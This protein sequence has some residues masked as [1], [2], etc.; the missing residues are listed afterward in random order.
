MF[1]QQLLQWKSNKYYIFWVCV[2]SFRYPACNAHVPCCLLR[3]VRLHYV[4]P[5]C[6]I[7]GMIFGK[8][9]FEHKMCV[10]ILCPK[11]VFNISHSQKNWARYDQK[12]KLVFM[13][14]TCH[15]H[16]ILIEIEFSWHIFWK[17]TEISNFIQICQYKL[18]CSMRSGR[19]S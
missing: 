6:L 8:N 9:V 19:Q 11:F 16:Q 2:F 5:H 14:S 12:C 13:Y 10:L 3:S 1:M 7:N 4:S 17:S 18:S 15:S